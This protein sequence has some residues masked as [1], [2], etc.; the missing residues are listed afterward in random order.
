MEVSDQPHA[1]AAFSPGK[2]PPVPIVIG[3]WVGPRAGLYTVSKRKI[4]IPHQDSNPDH[5]IVQPVVV[6][7]PTELSQLLKFIHPEI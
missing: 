4:P 3:V 6:A 5:P 2:E 1:S 7:V